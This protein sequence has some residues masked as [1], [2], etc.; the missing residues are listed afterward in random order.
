MGTVLVRD[1]REGKDTWTIWIM[2]LKCE[3][4]GGLMDQLGPS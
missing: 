4:A 1:K 2:R 3:P